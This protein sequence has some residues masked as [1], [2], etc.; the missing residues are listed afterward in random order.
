MKELY[1]L[2]HILR[3]K[4]IEFTCEVHQQISPKFIARRKH[5]RIAFNLMFDQVRVTVNSMKAFGVTLSKNIESLNLWNAAAGIYYR[6][7]IEDLRLQYNR[8]HECVNSPLWR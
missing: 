1:T 4:P 7:Y 6:H 2:I 5:R 8:Y 3:M